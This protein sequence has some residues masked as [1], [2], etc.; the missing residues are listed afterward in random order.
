MLCT[1]GWRCYFVNTAAILWVMYIIQYLQKVIHWLFAPCL[2]PSNG[3]SFLIIFQAFFF[4]YFASKCQFLCRLYIKGMS[5]FRIFEERLPRQRCNICLALSGWCIWGKIA[6]IR[7]CCRWQSTRE[8]SPHFREIPAQEGNFSFCIW[9]LE[10][11]IAKIIRPSLP[12]G[13]AV[14]LVVQTPCCHVY[15]LL[16]V[17]LL[18]NSFVLFFCQRVLCSSV[19]ALYCQR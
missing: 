10:S 15:S 3:L 2:I 8:R 16:V 9:N 6:L 4:L 1:Q 7:L 14:D 18:G 11:L 17:S 12:S 5:I 19:Q 13:M